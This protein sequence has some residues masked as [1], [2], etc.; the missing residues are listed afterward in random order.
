[1][2]DKST[3][4]ITEDYYNSKDAN[5][6]YQNIWSPDYTHVGSYKNEDVGI[7]EASIAMIKRMVRLIPKIKKSTK[8]LDLGSGYGGTARFIA[9]TYECSITCVNISEIQN[10][11]NNKLNKEAEL[12]E[13]ITVVKANFEKLPFQ[14]DSFDLVWSQDAFLH[15][16]QKELVFREVSRVIN[17]EGRFIFTDFV[18]SE[19]CPQEVLQPILDRLQLKDLGTLKQ[20]DRLARSVDLAKVY[21]KEMPD[22]MIIHYRKVLEKLHSEYKSITK[23]VSK[24]YIDDMMEGLQFWI[25]GAEAGH[26]S[27][28]LFQY[29]KKNVWI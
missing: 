16:D 14:R 21:N 2:E 5:Y 28:A 18:K 15:S 20:Y 3:A 4:E 29:Q 25:D 8:F 13:K 9:K 11:I 12:D 17:N 19:D 26:I 7:E 24:K 1:M 27:W 10:D 6:F 22:M 23:K